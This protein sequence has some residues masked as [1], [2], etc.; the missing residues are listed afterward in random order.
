MTTITTRSGKGSPLTNNEV[1]ANFTNLND[2]KVEASGDSMTGNLSFGDNNKAIFGAGSDL[3]IYHDG[4]HSYIEDAAGTGNLKLRTN[5]LRIENAAG[6]ELSALFVQDGAVTLYNDNT[7]RL[8]T[9]STGIDVTG[10]I[11]ADGLTVEQST[12]DALVNFKNTNASTS[13]QTSSGLA[14]YHNGGSGYA[15]IVSKEIDVSDNFADLQFYY[16]GGTGGAPKLGMQIAS[17]GDVSLYEDTGTTAK[18]FWDAS[19]ERLGI[20]T[21]SP[22][23]PLDVI[24][25]ATVGNGTYGIKLTYSAGNTSGII[26]TADSADNLEF[27]IANTQRM[28]IDSSGIDVTGTVTADGLTVEGSSTGAFNAATFYNSDTTVNSGVDLTFNCGSSGTATAKIKAIRSFAGYSDLAFQTEDNDNL[29]TR[30]LID[31]TGDISFYED[32]G[33][34]AKFYWDASK[35]SLGIGQEPTSALHVINSTASGE[36][37][38]TLEAASTKNGYI[39]I[40]G[41]DN[42]RKSLVFQSGGVDKFSMGV[43]DSDELSQNSFFIGSGKTG[44]SGADLVIDSSGNV[45]IGVVPESWYTGGS[46]RALQVG[47]N[48]GV[49]SLFGTRAIFAS[50]YY[51]KSGTGADTYINTDEATQYYQEAGNHVWKYAPSGTADTTISW[52]EAMRIDASGNLLVGKTSAGFTVAGHEIK[53]GGFAGFTRDGGAPIVANRLTSDGAIIELYRGVTSVGSIYSVGGSD[54]KVVF[55]SDG[56]QYITGNAASNYLTFSSAN[57]ERMRIDSSGNVGINQSNP[58]RKLH[59]TSAGSGVVATFGDSLANNTIEVTRTTTNASYI[60]LSATSA[61]GGIIAGPTFTFSTCNSGGGSVTE[62]MRIDSS[63]NLLVGTTALTPGNGNTDTGHLLKNDGRLFVSSASNSQFNRNSDGDIVTFRQSGNLVGS[64]GVSGVDFIIDSPVTDSAIAFQWDDGGI[65]R[66]LQGY[67]TAFR[68]NTVNDAAVDLGALNSRFKDLHLSTNIH[69]GATVPSSSAAGISSEAVGRA[70]YS[71]GS[72]TGGFAHL[73]FINGNGTVGSVVTSGY[74]TAYNT[75]S[76]YRL[77]ENVVTLTGAT[78]RLNQLAPKRFN[79]IGDT[80]ITVDGFLAH[81]VADVVPE[82]ITG[83][84]DAMRD[85]EYEVTP[86]VLDDEGNVV[87]EAVMGTRSVPDYQGIDQSKLVPLL[88]ATIQELEARIAALESN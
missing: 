57:A 86:A 44:G 15:Q 22:S 74:A 75:S 29:R 71:R 52:S 67:Q 81:E 78:A 31:S 65:T 51:L 54:I 76:D 50:N 40:N 13:T 55:S 30:L 53:P 70:I 6:T 47:G 25:T 12:T 7:A 58:T 8:A 66:K 19:T 4:S 3:Q 79:F 9:T 45:G 88:V 87:T 85:E 77:K 61:V 41:D 33:T 56:D 72:G 18:F 62:R 20:G 16:A 23:V 24:G 27:R 38:A 39:Y 83:A 64:I 2:D 11:S 84:K 60:G 59:V 1:D 49:M 35:E 73:S 82:A 32:T 34:T 69:Q 10:S 68:M 63:G 37:I 21:T 36:S 43:G 28:K 80:E 48:T 42:R 17:N 14:L 46:M 26:D 5:T